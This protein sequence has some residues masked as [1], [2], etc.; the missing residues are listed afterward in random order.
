[1]KIVQLEQDFKQSG[2]IINELKEEI[3]KKDKQLEM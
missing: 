3:Q 1:M 2:L